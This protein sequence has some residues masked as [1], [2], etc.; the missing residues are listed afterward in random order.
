MSNNN[1]SYVIRF[2][3]G[4]FYCKEGTTTAH[5]LASKLFLDAAIETAEELGFDCEIYEYIPA[6]LG[7]KFSKKNEILNK[8][9]CLYE[10]QT[11]DYSITLVDKIMEMVEND[12]IDKPN[13]EGQ[14]TSMS[15]DE[16]IREYDTNGKLI[17]YKNRNGYE[18]WQEFDTNGRVIHFWNNKKGECW[19]EYDSNGN[20]I[21]YLSGNGFETWCE[22]DSNGNRTHFWDSNGNEEWYGS[23]GNMIYMT[24]Y[25]DSDGVEYWYD[26]DGNLI[27][28]PQQ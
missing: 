20:L 11:D 4:H 1:K 18:Y 8:L 25:R 5:E 27:D 3:S 6:Q 12:L 26:S 16:H 2:S 23:N 9:Q 17:H 28:K 7:N 22:Y 15:N 21:H 13:K 10:R 14:Y 24:H 19:W